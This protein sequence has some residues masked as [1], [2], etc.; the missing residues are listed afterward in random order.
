[1]E[2]YNLVVGAVVAYKDSVLLLQR[3]FK[4]AFLP[5]MWGIPAGKVNYGETLEEAVLRELEEESGLKG[6]I[7]GMT[8]STWFSS[9]MKGKSIRSMQVNFLILA[10][11]SRVALDSSS[12]DYRWVAWRHLTDEPIEVDKFTQDVITQAFTHPHA[13]KMETAGI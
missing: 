9:N 8:G 2:T 7:S 10:N 11:D 3:S 6:E 5:G 13:R 12:Q 4:E 1:M